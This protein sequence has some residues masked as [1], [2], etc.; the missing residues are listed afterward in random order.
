MTGDEPAPGNSG[1]EVED[2]LNFQR[3]SDSRD[4]ECEWWA[5]DALAAEV[6][7]LRSELELKITTSAQIAA[8]NV[9][10]REERDRYL[11]G[12][13]YWNRRMAEENAARRVA[14]A[15]LARVEALP[16]KWSEASYSSDH[17]ACLRDLE[18]A[19]KGEL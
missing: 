10:L 12:S 6:H 3:V 15:K 5:L 18:A 14:E 7:R 13:D 16:A 19:L 8:E 1:N 4:G 17:L 2:A 11:Q 9:R